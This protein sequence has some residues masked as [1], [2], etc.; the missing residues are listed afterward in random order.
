LSIKSA[1]CPSGGSSSLLSVPVDQVNAG[2]GRHQ[3]VR[4]NAAALPPLPKVSLSV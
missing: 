1:F 4:W 2:S 3:P